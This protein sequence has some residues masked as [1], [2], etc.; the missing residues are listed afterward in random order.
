MRVFFG[1]LG[2]AAHGGWRRLL[3]FWIVLLAILSSGLA[4]LEVLGPVA[5]TS[6]QARQA[7][8]EPHQLA[9]ITNRPPYADA[10]PNVAILL[11]GLGLV[12]GLSREANES[13]PA[14]VSFALSPY[15]VSPERLL[16]AMR[17]RGHE[18]LLS[19]P[20]EPAAFPLN[21]AGPHALLS[22]APPE[23]NDRNLAWV[24]GRVTGE[25]GITGALDGQRGERFASVTSLL[26]PVLSEIGRR[27][28][29]YID[30]RP[31]SSPSTEVAGR[32]VDIVIDDPPDRADIDLRLQQLERIARDTGTALGL[33]GPPR[34]I[35]LDRLAAWS[36]T[37][38]GKGI[39]LLPVSRLVRPR[40][41]ASASDLIAGDNR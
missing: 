15:S 19:V 9:V 3:K 2:G 16:G 20:L 13:L 8:D 33:A 23:R 26:K 17:Q 25:V 37:L 4:V 6:A 36:A 27:G 41:A 10:R 29:F 38:D 30:P 28:M 5:A 14:A 24:L 12:D 22:G 40:S 34:P 1:Q 39:A 7:P 32:S 35:L 21:D 18:Y 31:G 11:V